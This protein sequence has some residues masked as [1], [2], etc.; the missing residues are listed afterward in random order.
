[1]PM[2]DVDQ[3]I[4]M[5]KEAAALGFTAIN[6]PAFPQSSEPLSST[7][8]GSAQSLALTGDPNGPRSYEQPE[9]DPLWATAVD[10]DLA[11]TFHLGAKSPRFWDPNK[12]LMDMPQTKLAMA[13]P[14]TILVHGAVFQRHPEL[15]V[16]TMESGVGWFAW[17]A[18]Y[19]DA[20]WGNQRF[21][22]N[23]PLKEPP[24]FYM[25]RNV[26]GSFIDEVAGIN[27]RHLP[28]A[29]N[30]MWSS[31]YPHSETT[32][33][34]SQEVIERIFKGVPDV[35]RAQILGGTAKKLFRTGEGRA[36]SVGKT[37]AAE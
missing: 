12:F 36:R 3:T 28:G 5:I 15:K 27:N 2:R 21:W 30:I 24:S 33:P 37:V 26:Y 29:K 25:D 4:G 22:T 16:A 13:E 6:I 35:D 31:D 11:V 7:G 8:G 32:Y 19:M 9:F 14:L 17:L 18:G 10:L 23:S 20:T 34:H 1:M